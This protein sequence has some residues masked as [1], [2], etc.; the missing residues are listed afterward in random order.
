MNV[1]DLFTY[2]EKFEKKTFTK[3]EWTH[4]A[5]LIIGFWYCTHLSR[6]EVFP[7]LKRNI[8]ELN[9]KMGN[10]NTDTTGYHETITLFWFWVITEYIENHESNY[11][12]EMLDDFLE[13][14]F[15]KQEY[16]F[17]F[18]SKSLLETTKARRIFVL[19]DIQ[20]TQF[21]I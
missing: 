4:E 7:F 20:S 2:V 9:E 8:K 18:Y 13:S 14:R 11:I 17:K 21:L 3:E 5:H 12:P 19:P 6:T 1:D 15:S 16:I 10:Q